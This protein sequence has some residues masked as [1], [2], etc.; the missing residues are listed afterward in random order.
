MLKQYLKTASRS[1]WHNKIFTGIN[2]LGLS[3]GMGIALLIFIWVQNELT[4]DRYHPGSKDI[5]RVICHWNGA[6][7]RIDVE[8]IPLRLKELAVAQIPE[9]ESMHLIRPEQRRPLVRNLQ[10][11]AIEERSFAYVSEDWFEAFQFDIVKG[12]LASFNSNKN[13]IALTETYAEKYF[14]AEEALG[15]DIEFL[16]NRYKVALILKD[17][18]SNSSFQYNGLIPMAAFWPDQEAYE[19]DYNAGNYNYLAFIQ[20]NPKVDL[21]KIEDQLSVLLNQSEGA[22]TNACSLIPLREMRFSEVLSSEGTMKHQDKSLVYLFAFIGLILLM[23]AGLNYINLSTALL[24]K[25]VQ[26]VGVRKIIGAA[27]KH[28]FF[29]VLS[30]TILVSV[31]AFMMALGIVYCALPLLSDFV[32]I[33]LTFDLTKISIWLVL[34]GV[35]IVNLFISGIY[36]AIVSSGFRPIDL[37]SPKNGKSKG[38][39]LRKVLVTSQFTTV[40]IMIISTLVIYQQL[41]YILAKD[42]GYDRSRVIKIRPNLVRDGDIR[43]NFSQFTL[44]KD[45][46]KGLPEI[47]SAAIADA[48]LSNIVNQN[49]GGLD[50]EGKPAEL[51]VNVFQMRANHELLDVFNLELASGRWFNEN[52]GGDANNLVL[53]ETAIKRFNIPEPVIG[54]KTVFQG[55]EGQI[56]GVVKDFNYANLRQSI[57]PLVIRNNSGRDNTI[58]AR[59]EGQS[60]AQGLTKAEETFKQFLPHIPFDYTFLEDTF[61]Q[62]HESDTKMSIL[63]QLF[64]GVLVFIACLGLLGLAIFAAETRVKEIGIRKVL[65]ASVAGIIR[66]LSM[67]FLKLVLVAFFIAIPIAW[68]VNQN[69][70]ENF[71]Y[72]I[73]LHWSIFAVSGMLVFGIAFLTVGVQSLRTAISNPAHSLRNE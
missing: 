70:L 23:V 71:A 14:G 26:S 66:L 34:L 29:Q 39:T 55:Q 36:P 7:N 61:Q 20:T 53:N 50:W 33:P 62:M 59:I 38:I 18:P 11:E 69:W 28:I 19:A 17:N 37:L 43:Q 64:A 49:G 16:S 15:K 44:F 25:K 58:I 21:Q 51:K 8:S 63:F 52:R 27:T 48:A 3:L 30:E 32:E 67:D 12:S 4:F 40:I 56:I 42:V 47:E 31:V 68:Y 73:D 60:L 45:A 57:Q 35:L 41:E 13:Q 22:K 2:I 6:G 72:H 54:R 9:I 1:L 24:T 10:G 65:G 5:H 46:L